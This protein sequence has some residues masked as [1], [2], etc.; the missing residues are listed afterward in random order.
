MVT[1]IRERG[2]MPPVL[3]FSEHP[4]SSAAVLSEVSVYDTPE[5]DP[6]TS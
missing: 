3:K 4:Q 5:E 1:E 6:V 2:S